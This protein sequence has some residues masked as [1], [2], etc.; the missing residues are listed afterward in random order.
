[1][2]ELTYYNEECQVEMM[3]VHLGDLYSYIHSLGNSFIEFKL[4]NER[5]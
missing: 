2:A 1:M 5:A 3:V 4:I